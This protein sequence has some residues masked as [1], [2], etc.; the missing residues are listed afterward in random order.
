MGATC[1]QNVHDDTSI[2]ISELPKKNEYVE[3][4]WPSDDEYIKYRLETKS[5]NLNH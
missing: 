5:N 3:S 1:C 2:M 4:V